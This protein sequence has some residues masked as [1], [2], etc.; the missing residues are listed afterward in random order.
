MIGTVE[1]KLSEEMNS[2]IKGEGEVK[3]Y[4]DVRVE[5]LREEIMLEQK[6]AVQ[7]QTLFFKETKDSVQSL[8]A[9]VTANK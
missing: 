7:G 5:R 4:I 3:G 6:M 8:Y 1:K 9:L 2:K